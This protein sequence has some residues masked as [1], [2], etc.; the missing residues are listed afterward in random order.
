[1]SPRS[2]GE[3]ARRHASAR[4]NQRFANSFLCLNL[5]FAERQSHVHICGFNVGDNLSANRNEA[6]QFAGRVDCHVNAASDYSL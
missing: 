2:Y 1:M 3:V 5:F 6:P 4:N